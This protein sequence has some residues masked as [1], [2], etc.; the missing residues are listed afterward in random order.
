MAAVDSNPPDIDASIAALGGS[1]LI[2]ARQSL[3]AAAV[4]NLFISPLSVHAALAMTAAG[5]AGPTRTELLALL[6][7]GADPSGALLASSWRELRTQLGAVRGP[8]VVTANSAW[9]RAR[10][11]RSFATLVL[12]MYGAHTGPLDS[13]SR[14]N[15]WVG[16]VTH[17]K[18]TNLVP[19]DVVD[20]PLTQVILVNALYFKG[21]CAARDFLLRCAARPLIASSSRTLSGPARPSAGGPALTATLPVPSRSAAPLPRRGPFI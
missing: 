17:G 5:T 3:P 10:L 15:G 8:S 12:E 13:A 1:L 21:R 6:G 2:A 19:S 20:N 14:I 18:I 16:T 7:C 4:D 11:S 9:A